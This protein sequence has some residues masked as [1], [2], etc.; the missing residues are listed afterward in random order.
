M[1]EGEP[2]D[3]ADEDFAAERLV[4]PFSEHYV[5]ARIRAAVLRAE[6]R[7]QSA[8][9]PANEAARLE[10]LRALGILDSAREERFDRIT[11]IAARTFA[12]PAALITLIDDDRQWFKSCVGIEAS[13]TTREEAFCAHAI[14]EPKPMIIPDA[15]EDDRFADNPAV[16]GGPRIRF[17]AGC[18]IRSPRGLP[19]GTLCVVDSSPR[20]IDADQVEILRDLAALV[21]QE[22]AAPRGHA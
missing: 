18:P 20:E 11:R 13:E 12:A 14:L 5:R 3:A 9:R 17:Y 2:A 22:L 19:V 21:E 1:S 8:P 4:W 16:I 6:C 10:Q 7:W 15:L